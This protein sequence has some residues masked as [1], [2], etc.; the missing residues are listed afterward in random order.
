MMRQPRQPNTTTAASLCL[1]LLLTAVVLASVGSAKHTT[2]GVTGEREM[3]GE[4]GTEAEE[5]EV[6]RGQDIIRRKITL[7]PGPEN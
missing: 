6:K 7:S 2:E 4:G 5:E 1:A 3:E